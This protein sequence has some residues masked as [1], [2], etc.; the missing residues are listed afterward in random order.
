MP[1]SYFI[2]RF[3]RSKIIAG[4]IRSHTRINP[5]D[6][7]LLEEETFGRVPVLLRR[8]AAC[9]HATCRCLKWCSSR[10]FE[11]MHRT[12]ITAVVH[13]VHFHYS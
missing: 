13:F 9:Q 4:S 8:P 10:L 11:A 6:S 1:N 3:S 5:K 2:E 12:G 7:P